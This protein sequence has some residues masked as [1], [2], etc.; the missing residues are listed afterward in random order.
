MGENIS[1]AE[2]FR[3]INRAVAGCA[4]HKNIPVN[5]EISIFRERYVYRLEQNRQLDIF[6]ETLPQNKELTD[7]VDFC[8]N[9]EAYRQATDIDANENDELEEWQCRRIYKGIERYR[10]HISPENLAMLNIL[11]YNIKRRLPEY[12][13]LLLLE[14]YNR[15][16]CR[17][18]DLKLGYNRRRRQNQS[19]SKDYEWAALGFFKEVLHDENLKKIKGCPEK[20]ALYMNSLR[21]VAGG[22]AVNL[23]AQRIDH[24]GI[25]N[26]AS[27]HETVKRTAYG[28][29]IQKNR[30]GRKH[31]EQRNAVFAECKTLQCILLQNRDVVELYFRIKSQLRSGFQPLEQSCERLHGVVGEFG[32][33]LPVAEYSAGGILPAGPVALQV[34]HAVDR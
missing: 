15:E 2:L 14:E 30:F 6:E 16:A 21:I 17:I 9:L 10:R 5:T 33:V 34:A 27:I 26:F 19:A 8:D 23:L 29:R 4:N 20:L 25:R 7:A 24:D 28:V 1:H 3:I 11:E 12:R 18:H 31:R 32:T 22:Q 13:E